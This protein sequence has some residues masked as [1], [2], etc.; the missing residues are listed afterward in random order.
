MDHVRA[1]KIILQK[2]PDSIVN[3]CLKVPGG[4]VFGIQPKNW[5]VN[6]TLLGGYFKVSNI[7]GKL[8]EYSPVMDPEEFKNAMKKPVYMRKK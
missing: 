3:C 7:D 1:E 4:Y 5:D 8:T 2:Y 6:D